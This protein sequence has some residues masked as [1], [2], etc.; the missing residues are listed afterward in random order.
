MD[1]GRASDL[2][3][4]MLCPALDSSQGRHFIRVRFLKQS[5]ANGRVPAMQHLA[6]DPRF[7]VHL[8]PLARMAA[9]QSAAIITPL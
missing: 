1:G 6:G 8:S 7:K 3:A 9:A 5:E 4:H 2:A